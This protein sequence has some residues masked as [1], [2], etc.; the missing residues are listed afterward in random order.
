[1]L[2]LEL[3]VPPC[4]DRFHYYNC[5][6]CLSR[7]N[8]S[9]QKHISITV[10]HCREVA[11][12]TNIKTAEYREIYIVVISAISTVRTAL[13]SKGLEVQEKSPALQAYRI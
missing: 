1:M 4:P 9:L 6:L 12:D 8:P 2:N 11:S 10:S 13:V 3:S 5:I 7:K